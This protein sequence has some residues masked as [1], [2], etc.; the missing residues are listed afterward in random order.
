MASDGLQVTA[1]VTGVREAL[2]ELNQVDKKAYFAAQQKIKNAAKPIASAIDSNYPTHAPLSGMNHKGRT[3]W[4]QKRKTVI[5]YGGRRSRSMKGD[6]VWPL[7]RVKVMD[8]PRQIY[9]MAGAKGEN[10]KRP[11]PKPGN[12]SRATSE[13]NKYYNYAAQLEANGWGNASR[14]VW[15]VSRQ[16]RAQAQRAVVQAMQEVAATTSRRLKVVR[17]G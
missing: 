6:Q 14:G 2:R 1:S 4:G 3:G 12:V 9:D 17:G 13:R 16:A 15:K 8:A 7:V 10:N 11:L 5:Q